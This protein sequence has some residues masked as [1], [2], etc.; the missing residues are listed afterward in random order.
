[1]AQPS[2]PLLPLL[3][4]A[5][6]AVFATFRALVVVVLVATLLCTLHDSEALLALLVGCVPVVVEL[7]PDPLKP[8]P[9][10]LTR[11]R[12]CR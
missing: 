8:V 10:A 11:P 1:L 7:K 9:W 3:L 5:A 6:P 2:L 4:P 12:A